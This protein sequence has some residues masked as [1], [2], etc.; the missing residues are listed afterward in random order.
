M[1]NAVTTTTVTAAA[2]P[3]TIA[4]FVPSR[5]GGVFW[6]YI[7]DN[8]NLTIRA[9]EIACSWDRSD[10]VTTDSDSGTI[11]VVD[12]LTAPTP[13]CTLSLSATGSTC[14]D[15]AHRVKCTFVTDAGETEVG[16]IDTGAV[17]VSSN[18][19]I[20]VAGIPVCT[21]PACTA[22]RVYMTEA[23]GSSY[24][25]AATVANNTATTCTIAI[26]DTDLAL[27]AAGP[28]SNTSALADS[29]YLTFATS[30]SA[31]TVSLTA[32][33]T[34]GTW[35]VMMTEICRMIKGS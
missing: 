25:L 14:T 7:A 34:S 30:M 26:S 19:D 1:L 15:G 20:L 3:V 22:R 2:S 4:T 10:N 13:G 9:G 18:H 24:Y 31:G 27:A 33:S 11:D 16:T 17:T 35:T 5:N 32:T 6:K 23:A 29:R 28:T 8:L 21:D 12:Y